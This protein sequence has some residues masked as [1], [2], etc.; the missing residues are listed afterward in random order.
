MR[1]HKQFL[2]SQL[3][4]LVSD[5]L[6]FES[7]LRKEQ[8][9]IKHDLEDKELTITSQRRTI[10]ALLASNVALT[11]A[12]KKL[13]RKYKEATQYSTHS[14]SPSESSR[15]IQREADALISQIFARNHT[16]LSNTSVS[17]FGENAHEKS[18]LAEEVQECDEDV[19]EDRLSKSSPH[20]FFCLTES[21]D[22]NHGSSVKLVTNTSSIPLS[23]VYASDRSQTFAIESPKPQE[24]LQQPKYEVKEDLYYNTPEHIENM[25]LKE[26]FAKDNDI[27]KEHRKI[28]H[29]I[30]N[31]R[32]N[33]LV[34]TKSCPNLGLSVI[35]E[36][37]QLTDV[38]TKI[39]RDRSDSADLL[40]CND[41]YEN[42]YD[43]FSESYNSDV[44][45]SSYNSIG[46]LSSLERSY[47]TD[48]GSQLFEEGIYEI[49]PEINDPAEVAED[50]QGPALV[51]DLSSR[52]AHE[53]PPP[54]ESKWKQVKS[55]SRGSS[56]NLLKRIRRPRDVKK[57]QK[58]SRTA[59]DGDQLK[60]KKG[61]QRKLTL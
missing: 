13:K 1:R 3:Q 19:E 12:L 29:S 50:V 35:E 54:D 46:S 18:Y 58:A 41:D 55:P 61:R 26:T 21:K 31:I 59:S 24:N 42:E 34:S 20:V 9:D 57:K 49:L 45:T 2:D 8:K 14:E 53:V 43:P 51:G 36:D 47:S 44:F 48:T 28:Q 37:F 40:N 23:T 25:D 33:P 7:A 4:K 38:N 30:Y 17:P 16:F 60:E 22:E 11:K 15:L 6:L 39:S 56:F 10:D 52:T 32:K 5:L 27:E